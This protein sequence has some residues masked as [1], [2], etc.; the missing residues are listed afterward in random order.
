MATTIYPQFSHPIDNTKM[1]ELDCFEGTE[2]LCIHLKTF[3][4]E[5][6]EGQ[7]DGYIVVGGNSKEI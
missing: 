5:G 2:V 3:Y 4:E 7:D 1:L 6:K